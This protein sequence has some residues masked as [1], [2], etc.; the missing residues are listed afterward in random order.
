[1]GQQ[2]HT[3]AWS[4]DKRSF[5]PALAAY[6]HAL[7]LTQPAL[8]HCAGLPRETVARLE[9]VKRRASPPTARA[10]ISALGVPPRALAGG[11]DAD[12]TVGAWHSV[13]PPRRVLVP[14]PDRARCAKETRCRLR[15][16]TPRLSSRVRHLVRH[17]S[18]HQMRAAMGARFG[19]L[20][21]RRCG[22]SS[23]GWRS[24]RAPMWT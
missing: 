11:T 7:G 8:A 14:W 17:Q 20:C 22:S 3:Q 23:C 19:R 1:M 10:L 24:G 2:P 12:T 6:R 15:T 21:P 5:L 4:P 9:G 18:R 16:W 13:A